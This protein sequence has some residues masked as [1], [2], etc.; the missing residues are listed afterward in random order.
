MNEE[1]AAPRPVTGLWMAITWDGCLPLLAAGSRLLLPLLIA[2]RD[3]ADMTAIIVI[4]M[5]TAL[6]RAHR[7]SRQLEAL[8]GRPSIV[9]KFLFACALLVLLFF[10]GVA[11]ALLC[12]RDAPPAAWLALAAIYVV[13]L[14]LVTIALH[15]PD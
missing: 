5:V 13:Y 4:P 7:G 15:P 12:A 2:G 1:P 10:E 8:C 3:I 9:R 14:G 11:G 6:I